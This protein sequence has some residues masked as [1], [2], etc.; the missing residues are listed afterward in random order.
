[1][2]KLL[3]I[4]VAALGWDLAREHKLQVPGLDFQPLRAAFPALTCPAQAAFRTASPAGV[5][6]MVANGLYY[7]NLRKPMFW[8]Q[9]SNLVQGP[10]IWEDFRRRGGKVGVT[11]WQQSLGEDVDVVLSP[12]PIH[13]HSGGLMQDCYSQPEDLYACLCAATGKKFNLMHYWGPLASAKA[14]EWITGAVTTLLGMEKERPDLLLTYLPHLDYDLQRV[15][16][17]HAKAAVAVRQL[18]GFLGR[19]LA[20][21]RAAG[22][23]VLVFGDYAIRAT[24]GE[25]VLP[26]LALRRAGLMGTRAVEGMAYPDFWY[27]RAFAMVDHEVAHVICR[28]GED[29]DAARAVLEKLDGVDRVL[30]RSAQRELGID[31]P[32][33]GDLVLLAKPG[34]WFA[35]PWWTESREAPDFAGHVDIHNKPGYDPCE[36]YF[37]W[38]PGAVSR[39]TAKIRGSHGLTSPDGDV[40]WASTTDLGQPAD[41]INLAANVRAWLA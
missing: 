33:S 7:R 6:G 28:S 17:H 10:R 4:D 26:N 9:S 11:F 2:K 20:A 5:H 3:I 23:E 35:Y 12:R 8:E 37:G 32:N 25:A 15:G 31:H 34:R 29:R 14:S 18:E 24:E 1:M 22:H 13:K 19:L 16:P 39:N 41:L 21:A 38:P 40:A 36:L 30:D 27:G